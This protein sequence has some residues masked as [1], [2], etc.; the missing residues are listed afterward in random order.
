MTIICVYEFI[1]SFAANSFFLL[2]ILLYCTTPYYLKR[3]SFDMVWDANKASEVSRQVDL[4]ESIVPRDR[5]EAA[6]RLFHENEY[7]NFH[8]MCRHQS[9]CV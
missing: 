3:I 2:S 4:L 6:L 1:G 5:R 7:Q 8:G 9:L